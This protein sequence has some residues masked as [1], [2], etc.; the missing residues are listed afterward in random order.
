MSEITLENHLK[1]NSSHEFRKYDFMN[2][3]ERENLEGILFVKKRKVSKLKNPRFNEPF[4]KRNII[5]NR[6]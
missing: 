1:V 6:V 3:A 5:K 4:I 2:L